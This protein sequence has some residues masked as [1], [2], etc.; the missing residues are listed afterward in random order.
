MSS[1][2][3]RSRFVMRALC[4]KEVFHRKSGEDFSNRNNPKFTAWATRQ[5]SP[6][7]QPAIQWSQLELRLQRDWSFQSPPAAGLW[8]LEL[9]QE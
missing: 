7:R 3:T 8:E 2:K 1:L 5:V 9:S 4:T 6:L